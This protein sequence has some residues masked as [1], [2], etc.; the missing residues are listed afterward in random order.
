M[1]VPSHS[2]LEGRGTFIMTKETKKKLISEAVAIAVGLGIALIPNGSVNL[3]YYQL[4]DQ[5]NPRFCM[6]LHHVLYVGSLRNCAIYDG[7]WKFLGNHGLA[8]YR[9]HG[10]RRRR[11]E[12][13]TAGKSRALDHARLPADL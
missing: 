6:H 4:D 13:R 9:G 5:R 1:A 11:N 3:G 8:A 2:F 10:N 7:I 12:E